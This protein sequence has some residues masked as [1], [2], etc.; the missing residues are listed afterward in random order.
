MP[1]SF[2]FLLTQDVEKATLSSIWS[3]DDGYMD[4]TA[5]SLPSP[6]IIKMLCNLPLELYYFTPHCVCIVQGSVQSCVNNS[7]MLYVSRAHKK[8]V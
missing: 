8:G 2:Q 7:S 4:A 1:L 3:S 5:K 6:S